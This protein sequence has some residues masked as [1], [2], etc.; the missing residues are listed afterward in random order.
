MTC[1]V[2]FYTVQ[3]LQIEYQPRLISVLHHRGLIEVI[4]TDLRQRVSQYGC[5]LQTVR[6][7]Y[8]TS[9]PQPSRIYMVP[10]VLGVFQET[11]LKAACKL[12][13]IQ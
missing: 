7:D 4:P 5:I 6:T 11:A 12:R 10:S 2:F 13:E 3:S 1:E 8:M 9:S